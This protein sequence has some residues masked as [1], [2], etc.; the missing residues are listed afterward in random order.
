[1]FPLDLTLV[2]SP[3]ILSNIQ[4]LICMLAFKICLHLSVFLTEK[5]PEPVERGDDSWTS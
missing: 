5:H 3:L 2:Q 1:M 4:L